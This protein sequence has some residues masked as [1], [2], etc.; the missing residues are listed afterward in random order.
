MST[1]YTG[2]LGYWPLS[3]DI[4]GAIALPAMQHNQTKNRD[5]QIN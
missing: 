5:Y 1:L 2:M 4:K 3:F